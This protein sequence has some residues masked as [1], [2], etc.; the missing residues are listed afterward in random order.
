MV[1]LAST[2]QAELISQDN[3]TVLDTKTNLLWLQNWNVNGVQIWTTQKAWAETGLDGFAGSN[4]W[5]L[6][7]KGQYADLFTAY[8]NLTLVP[9]FVNVQPRVG[10]WSGTEVTGGEFASYF[11]P[12]TGFQL[13]VFQGMTFGGVAV[14]DADVTTAVPEPQTLAL[15][16]L[17]LGATAIVRRRRPG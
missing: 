6:P 12:T 17:A 5:V 4:D 10:Y 7:S 9:Q 8:G 14:R 15:V 11:V 3:G 16:L 1:A 2:A 13:D